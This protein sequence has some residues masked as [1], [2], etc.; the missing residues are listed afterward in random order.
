MF[1]CRSQYRPTGMRYVYYIHAM[2]PGNTGCTTLWQGVSITNLS[3]EHNQTIVVDFGSTPQTVSP[4]FYEW[5]HTYG[6][7][8]A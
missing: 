7:P 2:H 3:T 1:E 6:T 8:V 4:E 5:L